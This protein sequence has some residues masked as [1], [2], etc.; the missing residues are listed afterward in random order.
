MSGRLRY[1]L[2]R[3]STVTFVAGP[4]WALFGASLGYLGGTTFHDHTMPATGFG[5][6]VGVAVVVEL[7]LARRGGG[8]RGAGTLADSVVDED[9]AA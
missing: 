2:S 4:L 1:P 8:R 5:I 6:G 7:G 3:F 9:L